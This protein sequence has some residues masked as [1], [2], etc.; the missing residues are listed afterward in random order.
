M[1]VCR[2]GHFR[3]FLSFFY[4]PQRRSGD[5]KTTTIQGILKLYQKL[6]PQEDIVLAAPTG[7]AAKRLSELSSYHAST[8]H[9]LLKWDLETNTFMVNEHDPLSCDVLIIDEF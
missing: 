1:I 9:S 3:L 4:D 2:A 8:I 6:F 7:R 5:R